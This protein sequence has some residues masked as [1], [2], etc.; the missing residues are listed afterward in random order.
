MTAYTL[1]LGNKAYSSWSLRG[2][3]LFSAF[4]VPFDEKVTPMFTPEFEQ[5]RRDVAPSYQVPTLLWNNDGAERVV[6]DS[7]AIA[8]LLAERHPEAGH[9]PADPAA[10]A[11]ARCLT[12]E[13][14]ASFRALRAAMPMN[15]KKQ[16]PGKGRSEEVDADIA[17]IFQLWGWARDRF[18]DGGPYLFGAKFT[19][20]DAFFVPV[21]LR[22]ETY[23]V[24]APA[25]L[26]NTLAAL[27]TAPTLDQW[28][29]AADAE[30]WIEARYDVV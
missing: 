4:G 25:P 17:R 8:E 16:F 22:F 21:A 1:H 18:G 27:Q 23:G 7:L 13:M 6:W 9:W 28:R 14:H 24:E 20:A 12:A 29:A 2:W 5:L 3:L 15:L 19:V 26:V 30:P 10:R 11:A